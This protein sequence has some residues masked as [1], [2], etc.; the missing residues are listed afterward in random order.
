MTNRLQNGFH[1]HFAGDSKD[2]VEKLKAE[3]IR[4]RNVYACGGFKLDWLPD[5]H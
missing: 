5:A 3:V 4:H 1:C 2:M